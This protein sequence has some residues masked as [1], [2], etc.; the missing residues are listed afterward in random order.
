MLFIIGFRVCNHL[1]LHQ[2]FDAIL[3]FHVEFV[4]RS[5][6]RRLLFSLTLNQLKLILIGT[7]ANG[8]LSGRNFGIFWDKTAC[9]RSP[10]L[11]FSHVLLAQ[12]R[13]IWLWRDMGY[14][15]DGLLL[16]ICSATGGTIVQQN[17]GTPFKALLSIKNLIVYWNVETAQHLNQNLG[18]ISSQN[19]FF[20]RAN[21]TFM[22]D[23][24]QFS[25]CNFGQLFDHLLANVFQGDITVVIY[26][27]F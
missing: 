22:F 8:L 16:F 12:R 14:H 4:G 6:Q 11:T 26:K 21:Q 1:I 23:F 17:W 13:S 20:R 27:N 18:R 9:K 25:V 15:R 7:L 2:I 5:T 19:E 24:C 10:S 3:R